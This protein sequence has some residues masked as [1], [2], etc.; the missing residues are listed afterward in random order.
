MKKVC[1]KEQKILD[2]N[3]GSYDK[4]FILYQ[5]KYINLSKIRLYLF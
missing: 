4:F 3:F 5:N 1:P 2:L